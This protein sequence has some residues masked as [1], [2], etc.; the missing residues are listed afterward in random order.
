[1]DRQPSRRIC[2]QS[3]G[4]TD[5]HAHPHR[6]LNSRSPYRTAAQL[7]IIIACALAITLPFAGQ[8]FSLDGPLMIEYARTQAEA[9]LQQHVEDLD[10]LGIHYDRYVNTHPRF[11]SLYLS[12]VLRVTGELSEVPVH[13][14]LTVF[15][16]IGAIGMYYLGRRFRVS[17][18]AAALLFLAAPPV[19][20]SS[21]LEMVDLP[22][23][24][25]WVAAIALFIYGVD[26][27]SPVLLTLA[28]LGFILTM[29]TFY[30]GLSALALAALYLALNRRFSIRLLLPIVLPVLLFLAYSLYMRSAYG[31]L[32]RFSYREGFLLGAGDIIDRARG[33]LVY[34]GA[35]FFPLVAVVGFARQ[36]R[37]ALVWA[38]ATV[39]TLAWSGVRYAMGE[40][41]AGSLLLLAALFPAGLT[42]AYAI[43]DAGLG[44]LLG[45]GRGTRDS[46]DRVFISAWFLGVFLYCVLLMPYASSRY[47]LPAVP[48]AV[49]MLLVLGR[50]LLA[51]RRAVRLSLAA[52]AVGLSL[53]MAIPLGIAYMRAANSARDAVALVEERHAGFPGRVWYNGDFG[54]SYYMRRAGYDMMPGIAH[55]RYSD[56][57]TRRPAENPVPGD[58]I[59][60]S[61]LNV[62]WLP[63]SEVMQRL[64]LEDTHYLYGDFP[65][66]IAS[67]EKQATWT[68]G[69]GVMLPFAF[70]S[71]PVETITVWR[72][73]DDPWP[74]PPE[75]AAM[76]EEYSRQY[77]IEDI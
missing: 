43:L 71:E 51:G 11:L 64:R 14:A 74:M 1:M 53:L 58:L 37:A 30:Q 60:T 15:P 17:G 72:V 32:P 69:P 12:L 23:T 13:V 54:F 7:L 70:D 62:P 31:H 75:L 4:K 18:L 66:T 68:G 59:V 61:A 19:M 29:F 10:Y 48:A 67:L 46:R 57:G 45:R 39:V 16:V 3:D 26:R 77:G 44:S 28:G 2:R 40:L 76:Y 65:V 38:A 56:T 35:I 22:G 21:H 27:R 55:A 24:A 8:A 25:L 63:F 34:A 52:A 42:V 9:P 36:W 33:V 50:G 20:V 5:R 49:L 6:Q 73:A 47:F 41:D